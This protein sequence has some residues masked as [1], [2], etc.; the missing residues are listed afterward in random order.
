MTEVF[1]ETIPVEI[2]HGEWVAIQEFC[3][4]RIAQALR[5]ME[6]EK[7]L[8]LKDALYRQAQFHRRLYDKLEEALQ[9]KGRQ[10]KIDEQMKEGKKK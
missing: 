7:E 1:D 4:V 5:R 10:M 3:V 9:A 2:N 6:H 8:A